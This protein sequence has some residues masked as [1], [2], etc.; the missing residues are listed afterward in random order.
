[1]K[2]RYVVPIVAGLAF[3]APLRF[4]VG[5]TLPDELAQSCASGKDKSDAG[6][7][8]PANSIPLACDRLALSPE[9]R[10]RHFEE[11]GPALCRL[12]KRERELPNGYEFQFPADSKTLA[13][14]TEWA[15]GERLCCPFFDIQLRMEPDRGPLWLRLTGKKGVKEFLRTDMAEWIKQ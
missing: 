12:K 6:N 7:S 10:K 2:K 3:A 11:L 4:L 1:M 5:K 14:V 9:A 8:T 13:I 15:A